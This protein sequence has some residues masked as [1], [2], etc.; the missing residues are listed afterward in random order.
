MASNRWATK[1]IPTPQL[2]AL[3]VTLRT[4]ETLIHQLVFLSLRKSGES[5]DHMCT[6]VVQVYYF[7]K[8][9]LNLISVRY[10]ITK[11]FMKNACLIGR[12]GVKQV[13]GRKQTENI[14]D[15]KYTL[16]KWWD[17]ALYESWIILYVLQLFNSKFIKYK[18]VEKQQYF[19]LVF[20]SLP[21]LHFF[22]GK[23][24]PWASLSGCHLYCLLIL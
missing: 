4:F 2:V 3:T 1:K 23:F 17:L 6:E 9:F 5:I 10:T 8:K 22:C 21:Y 15:V 16:E 14:G 19:Q 24:L 18:S 13:E 20:P 11:L 7:W 12:Q